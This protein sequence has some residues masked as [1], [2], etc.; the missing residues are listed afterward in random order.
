[1]IR[2]SST[3]IVKI[4]V[5][6]VL[7]GNVDLLLEAPNTTVFQDPDQVVAEASTNPDLLSFM[8]HAYYANNKN[9]LRALALDA[10]P[11]NG[12]KNYPLTRPLYIYA[13][14]NAIQKRPELKAFI[15]YYLAHVNEEILNLGYFPVSPA[16]SEESKTKLKTL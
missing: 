8:E 13:D 9:T 16:T 12:E 11:P 3:E 15:S 14:A 6:N 5:N 7:D 1:M 4:F 2:P 10:V